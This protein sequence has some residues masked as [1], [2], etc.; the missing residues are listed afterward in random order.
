MFPPSVCECDWG[1]GGCC[2]VGGGDDTSRAAED[3][4]EGSDQQ[5]DQAAGLTA[6]CS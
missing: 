4:S 1:T 6:D 5:A 3:S 2:E